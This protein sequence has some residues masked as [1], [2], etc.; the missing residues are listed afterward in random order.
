MRFSLAEKRIFATFVRY[1]QIVS[2][3]RTR[4]GLQDVLRLPQEA[5]DQL[6]G[7]GHVH[8]VRVHEVPAGD[9]RAG[10]ADA[11]RGGVRPAGRHVPQRTLPLNTRARGPLPRS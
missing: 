1:G 2:H 6:E 7:G 8:P 9:D 5:D 10:E 4:A 11:S 3:R